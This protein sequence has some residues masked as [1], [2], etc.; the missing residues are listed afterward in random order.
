MTGVVRVSTTLPAT[1]RP[2]KAT[3]TTGCRP[4][5]SVDPSTTSCRRQGD[6][7]RRVRGGVDAA[8]R[9]SRHGKTMLFTSGSGVL[10]Q[11]TWGAWS[12]DSFAEDDPFTPEPLAA[13]RVDTEHLVRAAPARGVRGI[14]LRPP[15]LWGLGDHGHLS[16]IYRS[17]RAHRCRLLHRRRRQRLLRTGVE[18]G[19]RRHVGGDRG[20]LRL[21][22]LAAISSAG[23]AHRARP[24]K[25][26]KICE[27][28]TKSSGLVNR[29]AT[30]DFS[31]RSVVNSS[32][33]EARSFA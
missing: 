28:S 33:G 20:K 12:A 21:R 18:P 7:R 8:R 16:Q 31:A 17:V 11:R 30:C 4:T 10:M 19:A 3:S 14:V 6:R 2:W 5:S 23:R 25:G 26:R 32:R 22:A 9:A 15:M 24:D 27:C 1:S 13:R 29:D